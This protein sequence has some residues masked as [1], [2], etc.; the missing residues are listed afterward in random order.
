MP[1]AAPLMFLISPL[2][3]AASDFATPLSAV[4]AE[5]AEG[6]I[7]FISAA[8]AP[9]MPLRCRLRHANFASH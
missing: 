9:L 6:D 8:I 7:I 1:F 3:A 4:H 2:L 5:I